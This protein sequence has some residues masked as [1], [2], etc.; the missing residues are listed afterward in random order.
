LHLYEVLSQ[1]STNLIIK[2]RGFKL[3][4]KSIEDFREKAQKSK[5]P[6]LGQASA[7]KVQ[8]SPMRL[9]LIRFICPELLTRFLN[10]LVRLHIFTAHP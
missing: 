7:L 2:R 6:G 8:G 4:R 9:L 5:A 1:A 3:S 10:M